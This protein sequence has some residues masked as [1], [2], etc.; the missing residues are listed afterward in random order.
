MLLDVDRLVV[1]AQEPR[2]N[3]RAVVFSS[4]PPTQKRRCDGKDVRLAR[5]RAEAQACWA[6]ATRAEIDR[7]VYYTSIERGSPRLSAFPMMAGRRPA[8]VSSPHLASLFG[9]L[10]GNQLSRCFRI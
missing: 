8:W 4:S 6:K 9:E 3:A 7:P 1:A 5:R 10:A 2:P